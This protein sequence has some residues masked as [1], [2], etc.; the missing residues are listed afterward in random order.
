MNSKASD[1]LTISS[2]LLAPL[3]IPQL[4]LIFASKGNWVKVNYR[5][6]QLIAMI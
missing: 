6:N 2:P 5:L 4:V 1:T 3:E